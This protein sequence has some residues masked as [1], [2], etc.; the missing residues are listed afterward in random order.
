MPQMAWAPC[1]HSKIDYAAM[2]SSVSATVA[3]NPTLVTRC[4]EAEV[5]SKGLPPPLPSPF[6]VLVCVAVDDDDVDVDVDVVPV[7]CIVS[8][9]EVLV[10]SETNVV[11]W[12]TL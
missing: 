2:M 8:C 7:D 12:V 10:D 4:D 5:V 1:H 3:Y 11:A 9:A 6:C